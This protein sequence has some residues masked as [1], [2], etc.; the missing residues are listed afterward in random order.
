MKYLVL[1]E[2][3]NE[4]QV[5]E[6]LLENDK[7]IFKKDELINL[8]IFHS[9]QIVP[10]IESH[11]RAYNSNNLKIIRIGDKFTDNLKIPT[12]IKHLIKKENISKY[13]TRPELEMLLI[14]NKKLFKNYNKIKSKTKPKSFAKKYI[15]LNGH[16]YDCSC[17]FWH[18]FYINNIDGLISDILECKKLTKL[19]NKND[20]YLADLLK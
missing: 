13:L 20:H 8:E 10:N 3:T 12:S 11:I 19:N 7:L 2:G 5:L 9:R 1:C 18:Q 15:Q 6:L 17:D 4:K 14:I 16:Y